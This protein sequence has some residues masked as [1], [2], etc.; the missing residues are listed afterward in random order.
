MYFVAHPSTNNEY[1]FTFHAFEKQ[2]VFKSR[3]FGNREICLSEIDLMKIEIL[4]AKVKE[5]NATRK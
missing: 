4:S 3:N 2:V 5:E 1:Y